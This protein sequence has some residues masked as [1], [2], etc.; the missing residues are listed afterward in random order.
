M[1]MMMMPTMLEGLRLATCVAK[2][3]QQQQ[4]QKKKKQQ[5]QHHATTQLPHATTGPSPMS[6]VS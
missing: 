2:Q 1:M 3:L 5:Q 6:E 4:Q